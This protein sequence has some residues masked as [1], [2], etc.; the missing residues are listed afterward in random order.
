M[1]FKLTNMLRIKICAT[2]RSTLLMMFINLFLIFFKF[3]RRLSIGFKE[4]LLKL[5]IMKSSIRLIGHY[6]LSNCLI[7]NKK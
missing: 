1:L 5:F 2:R 3:F 4:S 7:I 6:Y